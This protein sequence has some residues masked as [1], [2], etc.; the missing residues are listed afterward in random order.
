MDMQIVIAHELQSS[1]GT[2]VAGVSLDGK[3][4]ATY[5]HMEAGSLRVKEGE[6]VQP[7]PR[8]APKEPPAMSPAGTCTSKCTK[9]HRKTPA[10]APLTP[11][12]AK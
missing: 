7:A 9:A 8:S 10:S 12:S 1:S 6:T 5:S 4:T 3:L 2:W 11:N